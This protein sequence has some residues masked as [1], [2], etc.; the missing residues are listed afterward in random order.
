MKMRDATAGKTADTLTGDAADAVHAALERMHVRDRE[1]VSAGAI[2]ASALH[3]IP[4]VSARTATIRW[5]RATTVRFK[6]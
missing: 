1:R 4:A 5:T 2:K 3:M 6:G